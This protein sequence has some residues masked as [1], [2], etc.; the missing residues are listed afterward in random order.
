LGDKQWEKIIR[1]AVS[2]SKQKRTTISAPPPL[3]AA[4]ESE[5][6]FE[7]VDHDEDLLED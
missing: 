3:A 1:A 2:S 6:D 7:L 5:S 4:S